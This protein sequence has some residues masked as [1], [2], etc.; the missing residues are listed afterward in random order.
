[1]GNGRN[2]EIS[3]FNGLTAR[4]EAVETAAILYRYLDPG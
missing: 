4:T 2:N 3:R 1:V